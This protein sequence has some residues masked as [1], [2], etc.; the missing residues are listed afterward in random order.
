[1]GILLAAVLTI[2]LI[3]A[4][5]AQAIEFAPSD[6]AGEFSEPSVLPQEVSEPAL[7]PE[8]SPLTPEPSAVPTVPPVVEPSPADVDPDAN[9]EAAA[10]AVE[11]FDTEDATVVARDEFSTTYEADGAS[12]VTALSPVP[13]NVE[14]EDG[15]WVPIETELDSTGSLA[16]LGQG[17][18]EVQTHP[19]APVFAEKANSR[20]VVEFTKDG[21]KLGFTLRG[22]AGSAL[23]RDLAPW[24]DTESKSHLEYRSV[25]PDIDLTYD[26]TSAGVKEAFRLNS[27]PARGDS[28]WTWEI[29]APGLTATKDEFGSVL[30]SDGA[31]T[32]VYSMP[33]PIMWDSSGDASKADAEATSRLTILRQGQKT[34]LT[35][36]P[37]RAWLEDPKRVYP[38]YVDP[39]TQTPSAT[40]D[41]TAY[42][43]NGQVNRGMTQ[44]GNTNQS[45]VYRSLVHYN[46]EQFFGKHI[47]GADIAVVN[48]LDGT[49]GSYSGGVHDAVGTGFNAA[50]AQLATLQID[51][52]DTDET[53]FADPLG[54]KIAEWVGNRQSGMNL[55]LGGDERPGV[56]SYRWIDTQL[57]VQ[58][59]DY[60]RAGWNPYPGPDWTRQSVTTKLR[61]DGTSDPLGSGLNYLFRVSETDNPDVGTVYDS[62]W[63]STVEPKIPP[64]KLKPGTRYCW[65]Q[66][67]T[68]GTEGV[69]GTSSLQ[70]SPVFCFTTARPAA[71]DT[72]N[73]S[74]IDKA[75]VAT[76]TP[77]LSVPVGSHPDGVGFSYAF[78]IA[79]GPDATTGQVINSGW[80]NTPTYTVPPNVLQDGNTYTWTVLTKDDVDEWAYPMTN[81]LTINQRVTAPGPAPVDSAGPV[82]VNLANGNVAM[83]FAS[84]SVSTLGGSMGMNFVYNSQKS[85]NL[86]LNGSYYT[87]EGDGVPNITLNDGTKIK[88]V[89]QRTDSQLNFDWGSGAP[90]TGVTPDHFMAKWT[91][92]LRATTATAGRYE[93]GVTRDD[94]ALI[95]VDKST[96]VNTWNVGSEGPVWGSAFDLK[97][98]STPFEVKYFENGGDAAFKVWIRKA[99][100]T[101][102]SLIPADWLTVSAPIL[103]GGW[104]SSYAMAGDIQSYV[105]AQ[106]KE[107]SVTFTD[108][109]GGPHIYTKKTD[110]GY[111]PPAGEGGIVT[112]DAN[113]QLSFADAAGIVTLFNADGSVKTV[114]SPDNAKKPVAPIV[115]YR[116]KVA[117]D[118]LPTNLVDTVSDPLSETTNGSGVYTRSVK[119][120]YSGESLAEAGL[121]ASDYYPGTTNICPT[122]GENYP[123]AT[124]GT[125]CRVLYPGDKPGPVDDTSIY[126]DKKGNVTRI[127]DPGNEVSSFIYDEKGRLYIVRDSL[128]NDWLAY[129]TAALA[130]V[131]LGETN[132]IDIGYDEQN[133]ATRVA[134]A[135]PD[136]LTA[137][138]KP[139]KKYTYI[140]ASPG[141]E[142]TTEVRATGLTD[143]A[144]AAF[145]GA[146]STVTIDADLRAT[147]TTSATGLTSTTQWNAKDQSL[148]TLNAQGLKSTTAYDTSDR[149]VGSYGPGPSNCFDGNNPVPLTNCAIKVAT[150]TT[151]YDEGMQGLNA[152]YY[153]NNQLTGVPT[154][155]GL[156]EGAGGSIDRAWPGTSAPAG[157][158]GDAFTARYT[159][160]ITFPGPGTYDLRTWAD[161]GTRLWIDD[162]PRLDNWMVQ[163]PAFS[164]TFFEVKPG[165]PLTVPIRLDY[166]EN[167][168]DATL[169]LD[170]KAPGAAD[171]SVVP[172]TALKPDYGLATSSRTEDSSSVADAVKPATSSTLYSKPWLGMADSSTVD[173][174]GLNL[175]TVTAYEPDTS[176]LRRVSKTMP[177]GGASRYEYY[178]NTGGYGS[179]L[180]L[181]TQVCDLPLTAPQYGGVKK[182]IS[183]TPSTGTPVESRAIS[184]AMGRVVGTWQTGDEGWTCSTFDARG[185]VKTVTYP[186]AGTTPARTVTNAY[187]DTGAYAATGAPTGNPLVTS[188]TD[189]SAVTTGST[190]KV[191]TTTDLLG[192][193]IAYTDVWGTTTTTSYDRPGRITKSVVKQGTYTA[194][195][196][197]AYDVDSRLVVV[198]D[199]GQEMARVSYVNTNGALNSGTISGITYPAAGAGNGTSLGG[200]A[201]NAAGAQTAM[202]WSFASGAAVTDTVVRSQSGRIVQ[203]ALA[204]G[205]AVSS[206]SYQFDAAGRL[207]KATI[208]NHV[209]TYSFAPAAA[210]CPAGAASSAFKNGNRSGMSDVRT[211][212]GV[213]TTV[214]TTYCYDAADRLMSSSVSGAGAGALDDLNPVADGLAAVGVVGSELAYDG[215][216]N[217]TLLAGQS[218]KYD[219]ADRHVGTSLPGVAGGV[220]YARDAFDRVVSR[221]QTV[222]GASQSVRYSF[223]GS[224]DTPDLVLD[225][226]SVVKERNVSLP[227]GVLVTIPVS[228]AELWSYPNLHGDVVVTADGNGARAKNAS[229]AVIPVALYDPFGQVVDPV[230]K[231][232]GSKTADDAGLN[233]QTSTDADY[234]WLGQH[235]KLFEHFD[236]VATI[237]MGARQYVPAL[238]RFLEVDPVEG[239]VDNDYVYPTDPI[240]QTDLSGNVSDYASSGGSALSC[241]ASLSY[242]AASCELKYSKQQMDIGVQVL[243]LAVTFIPGG[244]AVRG[245]AVAMEAGRI[246]NGARSYVR[247]TDG[248][249]VLKQSQTFSRSPAAVAI[250]GRIWSRGRQIPRPGGASSGQRMR[251][252]VRGYTY[253]A[254][255]RSQIGGFNKAN[256]GRA[257]VGHN[258]HVFLRIR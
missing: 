157:I 92:Y 228:G 54:R 130:P 142:A 8:L 208:P 35:L 238:G 122:D 255:G 172:G 66:W 105:A 17:G 191:T 123:A 100:T 136:G 175:T 218:L 173:P 64:G 196:E 171:F 235:Q 144:G 128:M 165:A 183:A 143:A 141:V 86:G 117:D 125:L 59:V 230:S 242:S 217:T 40:A 232:I 197:F 23:E 19:L 21:K 113:N 75:V 199:N 22:A 245:G 61:V 1:M 82:T 210:S 258:Y 244:G 116:P 43:S 98:G 166:L 44:V 25:F 71:I 65:R 109:Y 216:G 226:A 36:S 5:V 140:P 237:E 225:G 187:T 168:G 200:I 202:T 188:V 209:L 132:R 154:A 145:T 31:G 2:S 102:Q 39:S 149:A 74:P 206:S 185:R 176:Y 222:A 50:G 190:G 155:F 118:N 254:P 213:S 177:S 153:P 57:F 91:G 159:G 103:P 89:L 108:V 111:T 220:S 180:S 160:T 68:D 162:V 158:T 106:V 97:E 257:V 241:G 15:D 239:G 112:F 250:A 45:G 85:S 243:W 198:K 67:V 11:D 10:G 4:N 53:G 151:N 256:F 41:V 203:E 72:A 253:R 231:R 221:T 194:T 249:M 6:T 201:R 169:R 148:W 163:A 236:S 26:V 215:G 9:A 28:A 55:L 14:D 34:L 252:S 115:R 63:T 186:K 70:V 129:K 33:A 38:V 47:L 182:S 248:A 60:P 30:F 227:G 52:I 204:D 29:D 51:E 24:A 18:A 139:E 58:W 184:D 110:G 134:L 229:G 12:K 138:L 146:A 192:R 56:Y 223:T 76:T 48:I 7:E 193:G 164:T 79:T 87:Y 120:V 99:G 205:S 73:A 88:Q 161:D 152:S 77:T 49:T 80:I 32:V 137:A 246:L 46:Y 93:L 124:K 84:P 219:S 181:T 69:L 135:A 251:Q 104:S 121:T 78:R 42:K 170:W 189:T 156:G 101:E 214:A 195:Q 90:G 233:T 62:G 150:S 81:R 240:N 83:N 179:E 211:V 167:G 131:T 96:V 126:F 107:G 133:R 20:N 119:F 147:S 178:S 16:W 174:G 212:G 207:V 3:D 234:G 13:I 114:T 37:S 27:L 224:S 95:N 94:G 247:I 127:V